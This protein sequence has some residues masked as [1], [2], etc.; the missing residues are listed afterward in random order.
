MGENYIGFAVGP[1]RKIKIDN[2]KVKQILGNINK[3]PYREGNGEG[4]DFAGNGTG[5]FIDVDG[6]IATN[7]HVVENAKVI[8]VE[9]IRNG[10]KQSYPAKVIQIEKSVTAIKI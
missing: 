10:E 4:E 6:Y 5:F 1:N 7:Y 3:G 8:V 2:I 9:F